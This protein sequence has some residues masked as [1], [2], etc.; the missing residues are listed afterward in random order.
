MSNLASTTVGRSGII[1]PN[2]LY[3]KRTR[4][5]TETDDDDVTTVEVTDDGGGGGTGTAAVTLQRGKRPV[6]PETPLE[7][8]VGEKSPPEQ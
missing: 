6:A 3:K 8:D 2:V 4:R 5:S 1:L 7:S